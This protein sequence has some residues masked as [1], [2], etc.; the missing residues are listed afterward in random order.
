MKFGKLF[1]KFLVKYPDVKLTANRCSNLPYAELK[2]MAKVMYPNNV[3]IP[4]YYMRMSHPLLADT[5][6]SAL[7]NL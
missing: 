2:M 1:T 7:C 4:H 3:G 6:Y 5:V